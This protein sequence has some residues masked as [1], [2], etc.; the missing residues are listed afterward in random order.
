MKVAPSVPVSTTTK[1]TRLNI[2]K[3]PSP[4]RVAPINNRQQNTIPGM[5]W[6][7]DFMICTRFW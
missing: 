1:P 4:I 6:D 3:R 2:N 5:E 7:D